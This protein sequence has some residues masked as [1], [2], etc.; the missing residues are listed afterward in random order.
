MIDFFATF[1]IWT[2]GIG[3]AVLYPWLACNL[4]WFWYGETQ[5]EEKKRKKNS[6]M[7]A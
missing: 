5:N 4:I 1:L 3:V 2:G 6:R 7:A